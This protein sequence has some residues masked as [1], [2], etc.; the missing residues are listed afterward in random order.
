MRAGINVNLAFEFEDDDCFTT[1][2][3]ALT[4]A[5]VNN[6]K[7]CIRCLLEQPNIKIDIVG[8]T[9]IERTHQL[10]SFVDDKYVVPFS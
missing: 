3:T 9:A 10:A 8:L 7:N 1:T 4:L 2:G 6:N 5:L